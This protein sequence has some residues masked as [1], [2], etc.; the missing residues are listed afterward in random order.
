MII[1]ATLL[2]AAAIPQIPRLQVE[3][4]LYSFFAEDHEITRSTRMVE[5][6]LSGV[7]AL[8]VVFDGPGFDSLMDPERLQAVKRVQDWLD[9]R[10]EVDYSLSLPDLIAEMHWAFNGE[11]PAFRR[12]PDNANLIAQYLLIYDGRDLYD[13][14]DRDFTRTRLVLNL[15]A[16]GA[17]E[18]NTLMSDLNAELTPIRRRT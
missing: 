11:D 5:D 17:G 7:M 15:N 18:L 9:E 12:V 8:E 4:D 6:K 10:P 2:L 16:H 1:A 14:V 13:L 3:T